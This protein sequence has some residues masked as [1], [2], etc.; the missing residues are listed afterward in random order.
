MGRGF[1]CGPDDRP[2][3]VKCVCQPFRNTGL[4]SVLHEMVKDTL[5]VAFVKFGEKTYSL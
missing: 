3:R 1:L 5:I 2:Q 4:Q